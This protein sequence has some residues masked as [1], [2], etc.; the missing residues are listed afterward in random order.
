L[1]LYNPFSKQSEKK[2][3]I[4]EANRA[5]SGAATMKNKNAI[6]MFLDSNVHD[7]ENDEKMTP[8]LA[9]NQRK[10]VVSTNLL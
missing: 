3:I 9:N 2:N 10:A 1:R 7:Y 6:N 5:M 8:S 4:A